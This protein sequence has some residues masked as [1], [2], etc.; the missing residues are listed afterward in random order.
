LIS[1]LDHPVAIA[2]EEGA[3]KGMTEDPGPTKRLKMLPK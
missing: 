3:L 2:A 1:G